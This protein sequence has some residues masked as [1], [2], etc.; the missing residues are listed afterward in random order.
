[1]VCDLCVCFAWQGWVIYLIPHAEKKG[2]SPYQSSGLAMA[3]GVGFV[4][5]LMIPALIVDTGYVTDYQARTAS[6]ISS[7]ATFLIDPWINS[8]TGQIFLSAL[9]TAAIGVS[10]TLSMAIVMKVNVGNVAQVVSFS[11]FLSA[12]GKYAGGVLTGNY[13]FCNIK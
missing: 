2:L 12:I 9:C 8:F 7:G 6:F 3:G 1:M 13:V 4:V 11:V 10:F 5:G